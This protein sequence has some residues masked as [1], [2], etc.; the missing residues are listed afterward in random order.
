MWILPSIP[1]IGAHEATIDDPKCKE[2]TYYPTPRM[3][4]AEK[5]HVSPEVWTSDCETMGT[6][7][8]N[9]SCRLVSETCPGGV[10]TRTVI[11][12]VGPQRTPTPHQVKRPC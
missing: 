7:T 8:Q 5:I 3:Y 9:R 6:E 10:E 11:S 2:K 12:T 1:I 4:E